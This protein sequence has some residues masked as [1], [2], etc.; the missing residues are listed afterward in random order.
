MPPV[1]I[2]PWHCV[3]ELNAGATQSPPGSPATLQTTPAA[4]VAVNVCVAPA[5]T[6]NAEGLTA[7]GCAATTCTVVVPEL[8]PDVAVS[9]TLPGAEGAVNN[10]VLSIVPPL[11]VHVADWATPARY[12]LNCPVCETGT[13]ADP[14]TITRSFVVG[15]LLLPPPHAVR[16]K[17]P[18]IATARSA[19]SRKFFRIIV[20]R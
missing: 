3:V 9:V 12:A 2:V 1:V 13:L 4:G 11:A 17:A 16:V 15:W 14:G 18:A 8:F 20:L 19:K 10:P 6:V 7:T 5:E